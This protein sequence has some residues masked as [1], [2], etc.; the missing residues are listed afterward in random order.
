[1]SRSGTSGSVAS[2]DV[3][4]DSGTSG[5]VTSEDVASEFH[6]IGG[7]DVPGFD[8]FADFTR[9]YQR[10]FNPVY[11]RFEAFEY[12][13]IEAFK[14]AVVATFPAAEAEAIFVS[15]GT[16]SGTGSEHGSAIG[17]KPGNEP[18]RATRR[19]RH[20][21]RSLGV[22]QRSVTTH[23]EGVFGRGPFT[24]VA[25]L[26]SCV[27]S[28]DSSSLVVMLKMLIDEFG[29]D[30]SAFVLNAL[31]LKKKLIQAADTDPPILLFGTAFGLLS[32]VE[33]VRVALPSSSFVIETGGM[34]THRRE[35]GRKELH[36][37]LSSG[38][39]VGLDQITSE[40]GMCEL[41][42]QCY[43]RGDGLF[44]PPPWMSFKILD[45]EN[46]R[47]EIEEGEPGALA[48]FDLANI[49]SVSAILTE[50][51]AVRKGK[52][53]DLLGRLSNAELR[54]CNFMVED[55]IGKY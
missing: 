43:M 10:E 55:L 26:P 45:P 38:F 8:G 23:F 46:P 34:K 51:R 17:I 32:F 11:R 14:R 2:E 36:E 47:Q 15:S 13:P 33:S 40:Y 24:I 31:E 9:R 54:G 30:D 50:D 29:T 21:V 1:M 41:L 3:A 52:G 25:H 48:V 28:G 20:F 19:S 12:L 44:Y 4:S 16:G 35:I 6:R 37:R 22:Y 53:F 49:Y 7:S 27:G 39:G 42:S 5:S 18:G